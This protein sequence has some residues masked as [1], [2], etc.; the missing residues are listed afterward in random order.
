MKWKAVFFWN[1][2]KID[3][4]LAKLTKKRR[5]NTQISKVRDEKKNITTLENSE[6]PQ[7]IFKTHILVNLKI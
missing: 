7:D 5:E 1:T 4:L 6:N 3:K 2:N